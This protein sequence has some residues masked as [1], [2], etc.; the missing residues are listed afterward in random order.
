L[1]STAIGRVFVEDLDDWDLP[2]KT[3]GWKNG[4]LY[5]NKEMFNLD[6]D[7]GEISVLGDPEGTYD[8]EFTVRV[9]FIDHYWP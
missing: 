3:F 8:L 6:E 5:T 7:T 2:D 4:G 9:F 1:S